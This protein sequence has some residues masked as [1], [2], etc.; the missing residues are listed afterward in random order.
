MPWKYFSGYCFLHAK[1]HHGRTGRG[2][3][4]VGGLQRGEQDDVQATPTEHPNAQF[5]LLSGCHYD[6]FQGTFFM[7]NKTQSS[8]R[9]NLFFLF[10]SQP[11]LEHN[12]TCLWKLYRWQPLRPVFAYQRAWQ[13]L[14]SAGGCV[15]TRYSAKHTT[16]HLEE[17]YNCVKSNKETRLSFALPGIHRCPVVDDNENLVGIL[18]QSDIVRCMAL[19]EIKC[20]SIMKKTLKELS[21]G[22]RIRKHGF[23]SNRASQ[24]HRLTLWRHRQCHLYAQRS[25]SHPRLLSDV[26]LSCA[27]GCYC[28]SR[29]GPT[30]ESLCLWFTGRHWSSIRRSRNNATPSW[31]ESWVWTHGSNNFYVVRVLKKV[32]GRRF[33]NLSENFYSRYNHRRRYLRHPIITFT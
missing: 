22:Q 11:E 31:S 17:K 14:P 32:S 30:W 4:T 18:S 19:N 29:R 2:K 27:R 26:L 15:F 20:G 24:N 10:V 23:L 25:N 7:R 21:L 9:Y 3:S 5:M 13:P 6:D 12:H 8:C 28:W 16:Q 1:N 33:W